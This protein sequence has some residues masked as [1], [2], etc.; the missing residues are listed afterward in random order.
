[1]G[2]GLLPIGF[3]V[4]LVLW[5]RRRLQAGAPSEPVAGGDPPAEKSPAENSPRA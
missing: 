1:V 4:G 3:G 5:L 2:M